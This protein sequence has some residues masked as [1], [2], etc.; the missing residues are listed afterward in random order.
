V[1]AQANSVQNTPAPT[2]ATPA[3]CEVFLDGTS[4]DFQ[5]V[6]IPGALGPQGTAP[7]ATLTLIGAGMSSSGPGGGVVRVSC[8]GKVGGGSAFTSIRIQATEL[9][10]LN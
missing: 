3:A 5:Q 10:G 4:L 7:G 1:N 6:D 2:G 8:S 9:G